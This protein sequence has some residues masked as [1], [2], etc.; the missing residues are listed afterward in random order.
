M[1]APIISFLPKSFI[2][3]SGN[4]T[5]IFILL[6]IFRIPKQKT[7]NHPS[8]HPAIHRLISLAVRKS[9]KQKSNN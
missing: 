2:P 9:K 1:R 4:Q 6:P 3:P 8:I 7:N 5:N